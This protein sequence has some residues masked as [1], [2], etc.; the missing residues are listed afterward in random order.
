MLNC[1][2][3]RSQMLEYLY[4]L[5]EGDER[6]AWEVHLK[7]C[8]ACQSELEQAKLQRQLLAKAAKMEFASVRFTPPST[9]SIVPLI[10]ASAEAI[11]LQ[12][13]A[14]PRRWRQLLVAAALLLGF[15]LAGGVGWYGR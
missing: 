1:E 6:Q 13:P 15:A 10:P 8:A 9:E 5:L 12:R 3:C 7:D 14:Q 11:R 4:D 2:T